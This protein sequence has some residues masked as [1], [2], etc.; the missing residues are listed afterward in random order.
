MPAGGERPVHPTTD[1]PLVAALSES[2]GGPVGGRAGR[3]P[4][5]TPVRVVLALTAVCLSLGMLQ[6]SSCYQQ[7]WQ[8]GQSR[9]SH[10]CYS[11][12]PYLY[13]GR[14]FAELNWPYTDDAQVRDRFEVM[15]YPVGISYWAWGTAWVT[16][17][18]NGSPDLESRYGASTDDVA[19]RP[20]VQREMRIF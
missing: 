4:W 14:G 10:M 9:Y 7:S 12:L 20:D 19:G 17:W 13:T 3:H 11:D 16:H 18:L 15:E 2:V 5:W 1:D 8:D 6:K